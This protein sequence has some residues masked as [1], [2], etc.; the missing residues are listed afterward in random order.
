MI[1]VM[2]AVSILAGG[3]MVILG[4]MTTLQFL[5]NDTVDVTDTDTLLNELTERFSGAR[6]E[7]LGTST[8]PWSQPRPRVTTSGALPPMTDADLLNYGILLRHTRLRHLQVWVDYYHGISEFDT[9]G[10]LIAP[11]LMDGE[12]IMSGTAAAVRIYSD[13]EA[14]RAE[15]RSDTTLAKYRIDPTQIPTSLVSTDYPVV[16]RIAVKTDDM[17]NPRFVWTARKQ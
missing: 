6:W 11:G 4:N 5:R 8:L 1:E 15:W 9:T 13:L 12:T 17:I 14:V 10:A 7:A 2:V 16:I 3:I